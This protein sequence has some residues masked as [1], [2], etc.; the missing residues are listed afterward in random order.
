MRKLERGTQLVVAS[1]NRGKIRE[2]NDLIRP[3]GLT[4][5]SAGELGI[6]HQTGHNLGN[7]ACQIG[8]YGIADLMVLLRSVPA[9]EIVVGER[10]KPCCLAHRQAATLHR[11]RMDEVMPVLGDVRGNR[12]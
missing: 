6:F 5:V 11:I 12:R 10:L 9:E 4:A 2:I 7:L 8:R 3:Y 1:H